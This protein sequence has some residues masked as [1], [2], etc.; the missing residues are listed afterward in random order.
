MREEPGEAT[1]VCQ[2]GPEPELQPE[3]VDQLRSED[4]WSLS[5]FSSG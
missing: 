2:L 3:L 4:S 5:N 1:T